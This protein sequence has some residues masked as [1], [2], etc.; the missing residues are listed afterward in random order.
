MFFCAFE[1]NFYP[2]VPG[3][4]LELSKV[5]DKVS[6]K[7]LL[8]EFKIKGVNGIVFELIELF[9]YNRCQSMDLN[10]HSSC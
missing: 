3:V 1:V 4:F 5:F 9:F 6:H 7:V 10:N 2:E 8:N